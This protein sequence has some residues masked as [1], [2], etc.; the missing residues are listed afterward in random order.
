MFVAY[1]G[2]LGLPAVVRTRGRVRG[3]GSGLR[4]GLAL[5]ASA[6]SPP[7]LRRVRLPAAYA[8]PRIVLHRAGRCGEAVKLDYNHLYARLAADLLDAFG[9][10]GEAGWFRGWVRRREALPQRLAGRYVL[11]SH[12]TAFAEAWWSG[13]P[14]RKTRCRMLWRELA[15]EPP[16]TRDE[17]REAAERFPCE[18]YAV[19]VK[20]VVKFVPH[21]VV[22]LS[23]RWGTGLW[24]AVVTAAN[25]ALDELAK[26]FRENGTLMVEY[27]DS[28]IACADERPATRYPYKVEAR[29][30]ALVVLP[31][32]YRVGSRFGFWGVWDE[33]PVEERARLLRDGRLYA[34]TP[35]YVGAERVLR[36][37]QR[38][39]AAGLARL[40]RLASKLR[41]EVEPLLCESRDLAAG[42]PRSVGGLPDDPVEARAADAPGV[43]LDPA[44]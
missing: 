27:V 30:D 10:A 7:G 5:L 3:Q 15:E 28:V 2:G 8:R 42:E 14:A 31:A 39:G 17:L 44:D 40:R 34:E 20:D 33:P 4:D 23:R 25:E 24:E 21:I 35:R 43:L 1:A 26:P 29:G 22:G 32:T 19:R 38:V 37:E 16:L 41:V 6:L 13:D 9:Y 12:P 18:A 11:F 36:C